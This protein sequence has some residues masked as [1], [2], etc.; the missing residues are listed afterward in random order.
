MALAQQCWLPVTEV[1]TSHGGAIEA[2]SDETS[3]VI[4]SALPPPLSLAPCLQSGGTLLPVLL[5]P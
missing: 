5:P 1:G 3:G 2:K 4:I